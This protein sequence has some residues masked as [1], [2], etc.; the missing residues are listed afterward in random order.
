MRLL[1]AKAAGMDNAV[2]RTPASSTP[3][4]FHQRCAEVLA[5]ALG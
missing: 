2:P 3:T 1:A 5:P 4:T